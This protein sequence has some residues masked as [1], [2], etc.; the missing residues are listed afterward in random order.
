MFFIVFFAILAVIVAEVINMRKRRHRVGEDEQ[1]AKQITE[2]E[3]RK[4]LEEKRRKAEDEAQQRIEE[5]TRSKVDEERKR[6]ADELRKVEEESK[7]IEEEAQRKVQKEEQLWKAE[8]E[9]QEKAKKEELGRLEVELHQ[10]K[11]EQRKAEDE[12]RKAE[13]ACKCAE[14]ESQQKKEEARGRERRSP[15]R[16]GGR[17][18]GST[19]RREMEQGPR[20]KFRFLKPEI[21]CWNEGWRWIVG[22][23]VPEELETPSIAQNEEHLDQDT[24]DESR[25]RLRHAE[26][27]VKVTWAGGQKDIPVV[28]AERNYLIFK[29]RKDWKGLGRLVR[30][31]TTGYYLAIV[32]P[33][34]ERDEET[35]GPAP[36]VPESVQLDGYKAHFF[37]QEQDGN[38]AIGFITTNEQRIRVESGRPHFQLVGREIDDASEYMGPLFGEQPPRIQTLDKKGWNDVGV[39]V[40]GEE[41]SSRNRWRTQF[42]PQ[43][44]VKKHKLPEEI[45]DRRG[46]WYFVRTYDNDDNLLESMDFRFMIALKDIRMESSDCLPCPNGYDNVTVEFLHQ[47][48]CKVELIDEDTEHALEIRRENGQTIV[49]VPPEPDC[50]KTHWILR[51]GDAEIEITLLV[52]RIWWALGVIRTAPVDWADKPIT[53]SRGDFAATS[54][55]ALWVRLPRLRFVRK[56]DVGFDRAKSSSYPVEVE[57]KEIAIPLREFCDAK[58]IE[59][60][61]DKIE[62]KIWAQPEGA[63]TDETV[64][65]KVPAEQPPPVEP[66][67]G[68]VQ[69]TIPKEEK[70]C[71]LQATVKCRRGERKGKGFSRNEIT[72]AEITM[73]DVKH[74]RIPYDKRRKTLHSW[75]VESLKHLMRGD[76]HADDGG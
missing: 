28:G 20:A 11:D 12:H 21:I 1:D 29:M 39:I 23:E 9:A 45:A 58:E 4:K 38:M 3:E 2:E 69:K 33:G 24:T 43:V 59:N 46:G 63:K 47:T 76:K 54:K 37:Y 15:L 75:N 18:R 57:K 30:H 6:L 74:F 60:R 64:V 51:E 67:Q 31:P 25:Y 5:E 13:E 55:K 42:I 66:K 70:A 26:G 32:P 35:S 19:K 68:Q 71:L 16:R 52:E 62:M 44:D 22:I 73:E 8:K 48:N 36:V 17:S 34:W 53:M 49:T 72:E 61:Q 56:I 50:D 14:K 41:G 65:V 7:R 27:L 40:V 10:D